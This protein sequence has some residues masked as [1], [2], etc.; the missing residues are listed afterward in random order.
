MEQLRRVVDPELRRDI[1]DP[2]LV[3]GVAIHGENVAVRMT[4]TTPGCPMQAPIMDGVRR[5]LHQL[6][7]VATA[8]VQLVWQPRWTPERIVG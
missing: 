6:P 1:V 7:W 5:V 8:S 2:G 4:L 3:Y